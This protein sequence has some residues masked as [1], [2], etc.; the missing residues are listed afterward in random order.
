MDC[1]STLFQKKAAD[2]EISLTQWYIKM[3][4]KTKYYWVQ[5][6]GT[7]KSSS[8]KRDLVQL[9]CSTNNTHINYKTK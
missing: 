1:I 2:Y 7:R 4:K 8:G 6:S 5:K 9:Y 3:K